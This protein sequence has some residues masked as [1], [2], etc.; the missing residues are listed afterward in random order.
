MQNDKI[1]VIVLV[2]VALLVGFT[3]I[4]GCTNA[5]QTSNQQA[6]S[7]K[8]A[9]VY[10]SIQTCIDKCGN[11]KCSSTQQY[12]CFEMECYKWMQEKE[13]PQNPLFNDRASCIRYLQKEWKN[14]NP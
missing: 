8:T 5:S 4:S 10:P 11:G 6:S 12:A 9:V 1:I 3:I 2:L 13:N 14:N 7:Q